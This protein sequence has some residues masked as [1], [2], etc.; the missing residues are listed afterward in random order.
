MDPRLLYNSRHG[1]ACILPLLSAIMPHLQFLL[2]YGS[3]TASLFLQ[4]MKKVGQERHGLS[5]PFS[6]WWPLHD[7]SS[8]P[9]RA[10]QSKLR[11]M[12]LAKLYP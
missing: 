3:P 8:R 11:R 10:L 4:G 9:L 1:R 6:P 12:C 2:S 5:S 7:T